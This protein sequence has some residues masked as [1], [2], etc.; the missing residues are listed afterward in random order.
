MGGVE[1][2]DEE[3][4]VSFS[5]MLEASFCDNVFQEVPVKFGFGPRLY[6]VQ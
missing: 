2:G 5:C 4:G 1:R 3:Y 6:A